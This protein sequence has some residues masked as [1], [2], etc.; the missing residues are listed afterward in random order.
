M[1]NFIFNFDIVELY[2]TR[3]KEAL[4]NSFVCMFSYKTK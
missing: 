1:L 3:V 4:V 2:E